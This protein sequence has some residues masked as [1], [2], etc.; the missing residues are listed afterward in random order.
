MSKLDSANIR[1]P[2]NPG[3]W[4]RHEGSEAPQPFYDIITSAEKCI[5]GSITVGDDFLNVLDS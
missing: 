1:D 4:H 5:R 3:Y 2:N